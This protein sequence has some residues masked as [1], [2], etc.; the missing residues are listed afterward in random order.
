MLHLRSSP[1]VPKVFPARTSP[2]DQF[3]PAH[4]LRNK[5]VDES[6]IVRFPPEC[7][8]TGHMKFSIR[9]TLWFTAATALIVTLV[10]ISRQHAAHVQSLGKRIAEAEKQSIEHKKELKLATE[11]WRRWATEAKEMQDDQRQEILSL[12]HL[13]KQSLGD[14]RKW[15]ELQVRGNRIIAIASATSEPANVTSRIVNLAERKTGLDGQRLRHF[16]TPIKQLEITP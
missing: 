7:K 8:T 3:S 1:T 14:Q 9:D 15:F 12:R 16:L 11:D 13:L 10:V 4:P 5:F 2:N 6:A